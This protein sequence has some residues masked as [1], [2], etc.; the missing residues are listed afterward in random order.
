MNNIPYKKITVLIIPTDHCNMNCVYCFNH[1]KTAGSSAVMTM[2]TL[3]RTYKAVLPYYESVNFIWHGG[4]PLSA[5]KSFYEQAF[6]LQESL[7]KNN[8]RIRN[9]IQSNLTLV[10]DDI[11][12]CLKKYDVNVGGSYDGVTNELTR[13]NSNRILEGYD[14]LIKHDIKVGMICVVQKHNVDHLIEDYKWF[15]SHKINYSLNLYL[16]E[17]DSDDPLQID[18][19]HYADRICEFFDYWLTDNDCAIKVRFFEMFA[20]YFLE[21]RNTLCTYSSCLGRYISIRPN[22][23][24]YP[25]NRDFPEQYCFGN[26]ND[27]ENIKTCFD[28]DGFQRLLED[29]YTRR[30][31]CLAG[32]DI[33]GFCNGGCN[34]CALVGGDV[35]S[36]NKY[37]CESLR[38]IFHHIRSRFEDLKTNNDNGTDRHMNPSLKERL[39]RVR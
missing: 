27:L 33:Y 10:D 36:C 14:T 7:N 5:G 4:E 23:D 12:E 26:V 6:S 25:C 34:N 13:H 16:A 31:A 35:S 8:A 18:P 2:D 32:C 37:Y 28:S 19:E 15:N 1:R 9:S 39:T 17:K 29:A 24:I 11:A 21:G 38:R 20:D 30:E 22:G 3:E